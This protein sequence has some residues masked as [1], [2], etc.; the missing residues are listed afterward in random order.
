MCYCAVLVCYDQNFSYEIYRTFLFPSFTT[1]TDFLT[2]VA[3]S[4]C[5]ETVVCVERRR[6]CCICTKLQKICRPV[7]QPV[8]AMYLKCLHRLRDKRVFLNLNTSDQIL[9]VD[10]F[11]DKMK[12]KKDKK[13]VGVPDSHF[14]Y[15]LSNLSSLQSREKFTDVVFLC[16]GGEYSIAEQTSG[17]LNFSKNSHL[18]KDV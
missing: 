11:P 9:N 4:V 8:N 2:A 12:A 5:Y 10:L 14:P 1:L 13:V 6:L 16:R 7:S 18:L 3:R 17:F 15:M